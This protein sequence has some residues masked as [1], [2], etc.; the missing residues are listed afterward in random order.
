MTRETAYQI[1]TKY[2]KNDK[3]LKHS[4]A[5]ESVMRALAYRLNQSTEEWGLAGLLH[6]ADYDRTK[7]HPEL[8]GLELFK[9]EPNSIPSHVEHAIQAHNSEFTHIKP[10]SPLDFALLCCDD[11]TVIIM[12]LALKTKEKKLSEITSEIILTKLKDK[13]FAKD[14]NKEHIY[15]SESKLGIPTAELITIALRS[16]QA[17]HTTL[18]L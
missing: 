18:G 1:L 12:Y 9:L 2:L 4:L 10:T 8:H 3:L 6:D 5:T 15:L 13:H 11:L 14:A 16:M 7:G 17:I